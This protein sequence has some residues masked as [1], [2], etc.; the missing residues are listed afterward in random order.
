MPNSDDLRAQ[1]RRLYDLAQR[2]DGWRERV[3]LRMQAMMGEAEAEKL[4]AGEIPLA[5]I[6]QSASNRKSA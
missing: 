2:V 4:E 6:I 3:E 5:Y 1:A